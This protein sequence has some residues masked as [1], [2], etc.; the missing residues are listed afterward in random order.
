MSHVPNR[1]VDVF[2]S[3]AQVDDRSPRAGEDG[4]VTLFLQI[5]QDRL[6]KK[7]G[8]QVEICFDKRFTGN[9][10]LDKEIT[11]ILRAMNAATR[12]NSGGSSF[13]ACG[14]RQMGYPA[15]GSDAEITDTGVLFGLVQSGW[16]HIS[17]MRCQ[18]PKKIC[19]ASASSFATR[20][21]T[22]IFT[23]RAANSGHRYAIGRREDDPIAG[24]DGRGICEE[25]RRGE[26]RDGRHE[27]RRHVVHG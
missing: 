27:C 14:P 25:D 8:R 21:R 19:C 23:R 6:E 7:V 5:A 24:S 20:C 4:W 2:V 12:S 18:S 16:R 1:E 11:R 26:S 15:R 3:Y 10:V 13:A 17:A 22:T 9:P